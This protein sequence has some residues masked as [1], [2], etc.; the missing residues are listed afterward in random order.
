MPSSLFIDVVRP[1]T[2]HL[3]RAGEHTIFLAGG[4][5][6]CPDWRSSASRLLDS[7]IRAGSV[8]PAV[9]VFD[10]TATFFDPSLHDTDE[11]RCDS[12]VIAWEYTY[13]KSADVVLFWFP[14]G[15]ESRPVQPIALYEL[16]MAVGSGRAIVVGAEPGY[17]R[18]ET[19]IAQLQNARPDLAVHD[20]LGSVVAAVLKAVDECH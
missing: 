9:T 14:R 16:G 2:P 5:R 8:R 3:P 7:L 18:R 15:D 10:P 12:K 1:L 6:S 4:I 20:D 17:A 19:L 11:E 13:L